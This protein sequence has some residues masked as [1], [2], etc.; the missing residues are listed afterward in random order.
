MKFLIYRKK[1]GRA[2]RA[3]GQMNDF[4]ETLAH[5]ELLDLGARGP[6]YTWNNGQ[7]RR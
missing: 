5:C 6:H 3:S 4:R 2:G 7:L 1:F